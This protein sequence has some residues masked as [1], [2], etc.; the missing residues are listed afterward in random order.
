MLQVRQ[1]SDN[2]DAWYVSVAN[3]VRRGTSLEDDLLKL[4]REEMAQFFDVV[5]AKEFRQIELKYSNPRVIM[6]QVAEK[7]ME[8]DR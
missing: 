4:V 3:S 5:N 8:M 7:V 2:S 1:D 6:Y